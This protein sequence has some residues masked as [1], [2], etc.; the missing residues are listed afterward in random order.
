MFFQ[1]SFPRICGK[2]F[3]EE[4][5]LVVTSR[6]LYSI[7]LNN[8]TVRKQDIRD[9][10]EYD[11]RAVA[12]DI[13]NHFVFSATTVGEHTRISRSYSDSREVTTI[14]LNL[15]NPGVKNSY[16]THIPLKADSLHY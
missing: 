16:G 4:K 2:F 3:A 15:E 5:L 14:V 10:S 6:D 9:P 12:F 1:N 13:R 7:G 11:I 8:E